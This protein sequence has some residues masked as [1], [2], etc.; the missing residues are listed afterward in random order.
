MNVYNN[1]S[2]KGQWLTSLKTT[3][4]LAFKIVFLNRLYIV[5]AAAVFTI[6]WIT[7]NVFDQLLFFS[8]VLTFYL[9]GDA[10]I[11]FIITNITSLLMGILVAMNLYVIRNSKVKLDR[12]LFSGSI[13]GVASSA[14][15][16]CSSS[17]FLIISTFGGILTTDY[18]TNYQTPLRI[19]SIAILFW[20]LY[21][22]HNKITN[23]AFLIID[24][25][26]KIEVYNSKN[27]KDSWF[28]IQSKSKTKYK[29]NRQRLIRNL[30]NM[31]TE[32]YDGWNL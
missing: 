5:I 11:A 29:K 23:H 9:P 20:A 2:K 12:S 1:I 21:S 17:G 27:K 19:A 26:I 14:C 10:I 22:I 7:F 31:L 18:L 15:A 30:S 6:F 4:P 25:P 13:L 24:Y 32:F 28:Q 16:S 3:I 8:P